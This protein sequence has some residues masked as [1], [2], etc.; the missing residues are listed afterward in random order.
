[1]TKPNEPNLMNPVIFTGQRTWGPPSKVPVPICF[2]KKFLFQLNCSWPC[3]GPLLL[4]N[5]PKLTI[6]SHYTRHKLSICYVPGI[7]WFYLHILPQLIFMTT[8]KVG[9]YYP[10]LNNQENGFIGG[11]TMPVCLELSG[12]PG[13]RTW[14]HNT[15]TVPDKPGWVGQPRLREVK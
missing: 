2:F 4:S 13:L 1:M 9:Y 12:L 5:L 3:L 7:V 11:S 10:Y 8:L 14:Y 6:F 15:R